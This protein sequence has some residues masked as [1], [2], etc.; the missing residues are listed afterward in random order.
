MNLSFVPEDTHG[1]PCFRYRLSDH[2]ALSAALVA[3]AYAQRQQCPEG[4]NY[5]HYRGETAWHSPPLSL[6]GATAPLLELI[7]RVIA[8]RWQAAGWTRDSHP[9]RVAHLWANIARPGD[10]TLSHHHLA[11][12]GNAVFGG[13]YYAQVPAEGGAFLACSPDAGLEAWGSVRPRDFAPFDVTRWWSVEPQAGDVLLFPAWVVHAVA[14]NRS[15]QDRIAWTFLCEM[16]P[17]LAVDP[18]RDVPEY[19]PLSRH[20]AWLQM[21]PRPKV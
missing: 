7:D 15:Q 6:G 1:V 14:P 16:D 17:T 11:H 18:R 5:G 4:I 10:F 8:L 12:G 19:K 2:H 9:W 3:Q 20:P 13:T 21:L